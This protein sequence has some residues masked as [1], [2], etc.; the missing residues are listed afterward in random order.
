MGKKSEDKPKGKPHR[1][2][3][4]TRP[5]SPGRPR[6]SDDTKQLRAISQEQI[7]HVGDL[8]MQG[9]R[10]NLQNVVKDH[11]QPVIVLALAGCALNA[12]ETCNWEMFNSMFDRICGGIRQQKKVV[13]SGRIDSTTE[14]TNVGAELSPTD[15]KALIKELKNDV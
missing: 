12:L 8:I 1:W 7:D 6:I 14:N 11:T 4:E 9:D 13:H 15:I 3:K 10:L 2:T 5:K